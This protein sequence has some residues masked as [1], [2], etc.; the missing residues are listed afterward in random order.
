[1]LYGFICANGNSP[2]FNDALR[3][4]RIAVTEYGVSIANILED[5]RIPDGKNNKRK[6]KTDEP[7]DNLIDSLKEGDIL[8]VYKLSKIAKSARS[9]YDLCTKLQQNGIELISIKE[10]FSLQEQGDSFITACNIIADM[11]SD[12][13]KGKAKIS[14]VK[15]AQTGNVGGRPKADKDTVAKAMEMYASGEY[16]IK[17]IVEKTGLSHMTIHRKAKEREIKHP[18]RR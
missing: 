16:Q 8:V 2:A 5:I 17:E 9:L 18:K 3:E 11:E 14:R 12:I 15:A 1:M 10:R 4:Q 6:N 7:L 13:M